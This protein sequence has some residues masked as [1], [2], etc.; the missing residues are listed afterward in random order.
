MKPKG[1]FPGDSAAE[2]Q[3]P[4]RPEAGK[5]SSQDFRLRMAIDF[6]V[7]GDLRFCSH[8]E[9]MRMLTRSCVR[10]ELPLRYTSGFNPHPRLS[11]PLPK[12][13]GIASEAERLVLELS[14]PIE[15]E[16]VMNRL[17][18]VLPEG[19]V[20]ESARKLE[21][22]KGPVASQVTYT[23]SLEHVNHAEVSRKAAELMKFEPIPYRR[24]I[25]GQTQPRE[26]DLRPYIDAIRVEADQVWFTL[27]VTPGGTAKPA[28]ICDVLGVGKTHVNH[29]I[30]RRAVTWI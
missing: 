15:I 1:A 4:C 5:G 24:E 18:A 22:N 14:E 26:I 19:V 12:P 16:E 3:E 21:S 10:A 27:N 20:L 23:A 9:M 13:V 2:D 7:T 6:A 28:E 25:H 17:Q 11:L 30:C 8:Q 29:L